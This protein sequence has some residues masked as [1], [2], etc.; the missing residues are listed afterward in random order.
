ME[1]SIKRQ[2]SDFVSALKHRMRTPVQSAVTVTKLFMEGAFGN[3]TTEQLEI[4]RVLLSDLQG[5]LILINVMEDI[6]SYQNE[7]KILNITTVSVSTLFDE[8]TRKVSVRAGIKLSSEVEGDE[9]LLSGDPVE[10]AKLLSQLLDNAI[11]FARQ[12]VHLRA[13]PDD[14]NT[15]IRITVSDDGCGIVPGDIDWMFDRFYEC[16][17][18]GKYAPATGTGLCL[19]AQ[20]ARAHGGSISCQSEPDDGTVFIVK[21]P[22][23]PLSDD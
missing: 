16:S 23:Q 18:A 2:R 20:I 12:F 21:L 7:S 11:K 15:T 8:V 13:A 6:Y 22:V 10:L 19:C 14:D 17:S 9:L 5:L 3:L 4:M 1:D